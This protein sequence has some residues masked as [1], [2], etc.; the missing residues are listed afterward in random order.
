ME[1]GKRLILG[2]ARRMLVD[3]DDIGL[4]FDTHRRRVLPSKAKAA[5]EEWDTVQ[6]PRSI[7]E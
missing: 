1:L 4:I 5:V 2:L 6:R 3:S 7:P